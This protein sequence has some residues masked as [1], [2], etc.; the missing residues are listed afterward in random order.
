MIDSLVFAG[1]LIGAMLPYAFSAMTMKSVG[2]AAKVMVINI[3][4]QLAMNPGIR[5]GSVKPDYQACIKISTDAS[6]KEMILPGILV[7][8]TPFF[9][10]MLFGPSCV[11]GL[12][13]GALIS[14]V[15]M[16]LSSANAGGAWDNAKKYIEAG[17]LEIDGT[18]RGKGTK[19][20]SAA[21]V[22]DTVGDPL[23]DTS[24]P[25]L[26]ILIKLMAIFSL[27]FSQF[28]DKTAFL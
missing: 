23:K 22:G 26:N 19:E 20:H 10:G 8:F 25:A 5:D 24:G 21:V 9:I 14:G 12:L 3:R 13:P 15:A 4:E 27:V 11:A 2:H 6:L 1:L 7:L 17:L 18:T 28:F 16:A